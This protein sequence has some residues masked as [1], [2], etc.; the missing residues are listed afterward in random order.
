MHPEATMIL[1][2]ALVLPAT[3]VDPDTSF[4]VA[5][6]ALGAGAADAL[7]GYESADP[8]VLAVRADTGGVGNA[9]AALA[10]GLGAALC[11]SYTVDGMLFCPRM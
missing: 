8:T 3:A 10:L 4:Y 6:D 1:L 7:S 9:T 2:L 5:S 11:L